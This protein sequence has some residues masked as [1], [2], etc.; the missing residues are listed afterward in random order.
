M[1]LLSKK[2]L[3]T[4]YVMLA[5]LLLVQPVLATDLTA[6]EE[7]NILKVETIET[8]GETY[9]FGVRAALVSEEPVP[10]YTTGTAGID[11]IAD[12]EG[13]AAEPYRDTNGWAIG[14]G[15]SYSK[16]LEKFPELESLGYITEEQAKALMADELVKVEGYVNNYAKKHSIVFNQNQFDAIVSFT[17]NVGYAWM[18]GVNNDNTPYRIRALLEGMPANWTLENTKSALGTWV[19]AGGSILPGL[20]K[21]REAE[22]TLFCTP[23]TDDGGEDEEEPTPDPEPEPEGT[24]TDV[25][26][27]DWYY[28]M[29]ETAY[30]MGIM[31]GDGNGKFRPTDDLTRGEMVQALANLDGVELASSGE[32]EFTDVA[33]DAWYATAVA[34]AAENGIVNGK[35]DGSCFAPGESIRREHVCNIVARYLRSKGVEMGEITMTFADEGDMEATSVENVYFCV[36]LGI[37]NGKGDDLFDPQTSATRAEIAK[38]LVKTAEV[39]AG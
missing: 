38:I 27:S 29:V 21:R 37:I 36:S 14:Y 31:K 26:T 13:F 17:Y 18:T 32:T 3:R 12:F 6:D 10:T 33:E 35:G 4:V 25:Y 20:V 30:E 39:L 11:L 1:R 24:Y 9:S 15:S 16:A 8:G 23:W 34:W 2:M 22:A 5:A 19:K 7:A 28:D